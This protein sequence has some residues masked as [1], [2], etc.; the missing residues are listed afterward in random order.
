MRPSPAAPALWHGLLAAGVSSKSMAPFVRET[1]PHEDQSRDIEIE[2]LWQHDRD[3]AWWAILD[4]GER[5]KLVEP[6]P[7]Y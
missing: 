6:W 7:A 2:I 1:R 3:G 4:T 5:V